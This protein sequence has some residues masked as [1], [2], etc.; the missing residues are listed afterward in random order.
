MSQ[1]RNV[2][3]TVGGI[4]VN[5]I[6][7]LNNV[8][9]TRSSV[10]QGTSLTSGVTIYSP[11]GFIFTLTTGTLA[12]GGSSSFTVSNNAVRAD[13]II[14]SNIVHHGGNGIPVARINN[15][16]EGSFGVSLRNI[17]LTNA[18]TGSVKLAFSVL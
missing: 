4:R 17:D 14:L 2:T 5:N 15:V 12:T 10:S 13:S 8:R 7:T 9:L 3:Q 6:A 11:A 16:T 1:S 18:M